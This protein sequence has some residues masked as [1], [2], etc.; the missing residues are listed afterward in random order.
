MGK[1]K[2]I[3]ALLLVLALALPLVAACSCG[4]E[5]IRYT[6]TE[7]EWEASKKRPENVTV[8]QEHYNGEESQ[9]QT[10]KYA[11]GFTCACDGEKWWEEKP[12]TQTTHTHSTSVI[13]QTN[14]SVSDSSVSGD[15]Y[16]VR[17]SAGSVPNITESAGDVKS[18]VDASTSVDGGYFGSQIVVPAGSLNLDIGIATR[19]PAWSDDFSYEVEINP[20]FNGFI[21]LDIGYY[22]TYK[23]SQDNIYIHSML[24]YGFGTYGFCCK[25]Y[26]GKA[27][28]ELPVTNE[29][30]KTVVKWTEQNALTYT[31]KENDL[32]LAELVYDEAERAYVYETTE[33]AED[34][35]CSAKT[36]VYFENGKLVKSISFV[37]QNSEG[38]K[39]Y[40]VS[41]VT[42]RE[43]ISDDYETFV[44]RYYNYDETEIEHHSFSAK[45][46][47]TK[48]KK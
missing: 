8:K 20:D 32:T 24:E 29:S 16:G 39:P 28:I 9:I 4:V 33:V 25:E 44:T 3:V 41:K 14:D 11:N 5:E 17:R 18:N 46:I 36:Y 40:D 48:V 10:I 38:K 15:A 45:D 31:F 47:I 6:I 26:N 22:G 23:D 37:S 30:G 21:S 35:S 42:P 19:F 1:Y 13:N 43:L 12:S 7:E 27:Y 2:R 34:Y